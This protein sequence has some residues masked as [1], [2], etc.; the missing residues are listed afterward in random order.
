[1]AYHKKS[2]NHFVYKTNNL[3]IEIDTD[4]N[5]MSAY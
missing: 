2:Q 4:G 3:S 1:M 5:C